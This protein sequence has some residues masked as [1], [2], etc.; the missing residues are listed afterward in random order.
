MKK[1][2][3]QLANEAHPYRVARAFNKESLEKQVII[4]MK[5]GYVPQGGITSNPTGDMCQAMVLKGK[6]K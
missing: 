5:D 6:K 2:L 1:S 3:N 4:L